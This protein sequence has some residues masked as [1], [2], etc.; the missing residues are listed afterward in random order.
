M[1]D[2]M[3]TLVAHARTQDASGVWRTTDTERRVLCRID[4]VTSREF[5]EGGRNGLNPEFKA[6]V[7]HS[8]YQGER[9]VR[10]DGNGYGV[11]RT[12]RDGD[13]VELYCQRK[14][15]TNQYATT[16]SPSIS[17]GG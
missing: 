3:I 14:G 2:S 6:E 5:F 15:G 13:Y 12:Y 7:F 9:D 17:I 8:D 10:H 16:L 4:S 1:T 11:Y